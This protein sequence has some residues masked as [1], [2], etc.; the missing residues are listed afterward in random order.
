MECKKNI[1][2]YVFFIW[3]LLFITLYSYK[4]SAQE[5]S[6][7]KKEAF[8]EQNVEN[9][10]ES[11]SENALDYTLVFDELLQFIE[12]PLDLNKGKKRRFGKTNCFN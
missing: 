9:I 5:I 3:F 11:H 4:T 1:L 6:D 2:N 7:F 8:F 10:A 12:N